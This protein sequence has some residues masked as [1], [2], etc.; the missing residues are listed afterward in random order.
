[1]QTIVDKVSQGVYKP[2]IYHTFNF[3]EVQ[4]AHAMMENNQAAGKLVVMVN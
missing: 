3:N 2:N 4:Q 1:M